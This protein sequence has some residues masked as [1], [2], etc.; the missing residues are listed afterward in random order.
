[1]KRVKCQYKCGAC[2]LCNCKTYIRFESTRHYLTGCLSAGTCYC[3]TPCTATTSMAT[4]IIMLCDDMVCW[5]EIKFW[6]PC[7]CKLWGFVI[8]GYPPKSY[9]IHKIHN[10][11]I[12]CSLIIHSFGRIRIWMRR[13]SSRSVEKK[14]QISTCHLIN[15]MKWWTRVLCHLLIIINM[16]SAKRKCSRVRIQLWRLENAPSAVCVD[17][18]P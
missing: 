8:C 18:R 4:I 16:R 6:T 10:L 14:R 5:P 1:M 11:N 15:Q 3:A 17:R 9:K 13:K 2:P 12:C 7:D